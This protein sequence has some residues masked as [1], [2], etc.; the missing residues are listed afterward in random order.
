MHIH[1]NAQLLCVAVLSWAFS[2]NA[3]DSAERAQIEATSR[4]MGFTWH[5]V[6][7]CFLLTRRMLARV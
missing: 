1:M 7:I 4:A 5:S 3:E 6:Q 2:S